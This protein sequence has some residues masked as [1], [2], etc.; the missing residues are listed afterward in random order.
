M[1]SDSQPYSPLASAASPDQV[2][3]YPHLAPCYVAAPTFAQACVNLLKLPEPVS[4]A[5]YARSPANDDTATQVDVAAAIVARE[6]SLWSLSPGSLPVPIQARHAHDHR[7]PKEEK[8]RD[9]MW[10]VH[11]VRK[12]MCVKSL[13]A[14]RAY[15]SPVVCPVCCDASKYSCSSCGA[16]KAAAAKAAERESCTHCTRYTRSLAPESTRA[17]SRKRQPVMLL[18]APNFKVKSKVRTLTLPSRAKAPKTETAQHAA[19]QKRAHVL[20]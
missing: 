18:K 7:S 10:V 6:A 8:K 11:A 16:A 17:S 15:S 12:G 1:A 3:R 20:A 5:A 4:T 2:R 19:A 13:D 9:S 14:P